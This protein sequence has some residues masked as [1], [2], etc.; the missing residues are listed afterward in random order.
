MNR[1]P[2]SKIQIELVP[3]AYSQLIH[4]LLQNA[5]NEYGAGLLTDPIHTL[6]AKIESQTRI[7]VYAGSHGQPIEYAEIHLWEHEAAQLIWQ[8]VLYTAGVDAPG[9]DYYA[10]MKAKRK[11]PVQ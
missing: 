10:L 6:I 1:T 11:E 5:E 9:K 4:T 7:V 8:L 2:H 3:C